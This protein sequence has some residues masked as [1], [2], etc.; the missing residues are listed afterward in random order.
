MRL[1]YQWFYGNVK[2]ITNV[3]WD[4][5][6]V[7][8]FN[9]SGINQILLNYP[10][11][12]NY[13]YTYVNPGCVYSEYTRL[14]THTSILESYRRMY[15]RSYWHKFS[16]KNFRIYAPRLIHPAVFYLHNLFNNLFIHCT[17]I[18]NWLNINI[19]YI[20]LWLHLFL[21]YKLPY[22]LIDF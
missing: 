6:G 2:L 5:K 21:D 11:T 14:S 12:H 17:P 3:N 15:E 19:R 8:F 13:P 22:I 16:Y 10:A 7:I 20:F 1:I 9:I 18:Q 4:Q